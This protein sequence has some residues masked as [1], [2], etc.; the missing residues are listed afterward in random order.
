MRI[1]D[2]NRIYEIVKHNEVGKW[3]AASKSM[4]YVETEQYVEK[5]V[6]HW[7]KEGF[8]IWVVINRL[9]DKVIGH[10]GL[11]YIDNTKDIELIYLLGKDDWGKG[12]ATEAGQAVL[13]YGSQELKITQFHA[14]V[15]INNHQSKHVLKKLGFE[16]INDRNYNGR[17]LSYY[18]KNLTNEELEKQP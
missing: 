5:F 3:L 18:I 9:T 8:G 13:D 15:R 2:S 7:K 10:C 16:W 1:E 17:C 4:S 12:Y 6:T 14:R 11:R